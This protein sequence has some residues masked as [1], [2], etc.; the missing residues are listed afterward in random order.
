MEK[1]NS[2][3]KLAFSN[4][5]KENKIITFLQDYLSFTF[6]T[7]KE[8]FLVEDDKIV[9]I[10]NKA[11]EKFYLNIINNLKNHGNFKT[12][13]LIPTKL[14]N[15]N[16]EKNIITIFYPI[17]IRLFEEKIQNLLKNKPLSFNHLT[18]INDNFLLNNVNGQKIFLTEIEL[19]IL[20]LFFSK[21]TLEKNLLKSK[22]LK[23]QN[24]IETKSLESHFSRIR[25]KIS[26][27]D[28]DIEIMSISN[29][30]VTI[31]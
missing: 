18:I 2:F 3:M 19:K 11:G 30:N 5:N 15:V 31:K 29:Q 28:G 1:E 20:K 26:K 25:K 7:L 14:N 21:I 6:C 4:D 22:I 13:L 23:L 12:I 8:I 16:V 9:F 27:I 24:N 10:D 17:N